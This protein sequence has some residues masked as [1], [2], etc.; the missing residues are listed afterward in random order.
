VVQNYHAAHE[1]ALR[2]KVGQTSTEDLRQ[3]MIHYRV[4]FDEL[5]SDRPSHAHAAE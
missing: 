3:A 5:V 2:Y 4:L 1:I